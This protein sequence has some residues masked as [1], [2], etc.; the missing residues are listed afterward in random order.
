MSE[1]KTTGKQLA[2]EVEKLRREIRR[3][4][5][6]YYTD[7][8]PEISD[9]EFDQLM[10][11]LVELEREHPELQAIDSPSVRVGGAPVSGFETVIHDPPMLSIENAYSFDELREWDE[12]VRRS[13]GSGPV[14]YV[15]DLKIDGVS[16]DLLYRDG[17]MVRGATR[18]DGVRGDDVTSNVKT[19]RSLPLR[20]AGAPSVLEVRGE[21]YIDK[22]TFEQLNR[23]KEEEGAAPLANPRNS[24]AGSLRLLDP[25]QAAQRRL[26]AFV[27]NVVRA[28]RL[29]ATQSEVY[30]MLEGLGLP[31][32]PGRSIC[33]GLDQLLEFIEEW[34]EK[35]HSLPFDIDGIV[36]KVDRRDLQSELGVTSK[37]PR[38]A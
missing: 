28:D 7:A 4:E 8:A 36:I 14:D 37:A 29:P 34:R 1:R 26:R 20:L 21:V 17:V 5:Q 13:L 6:L 23:E 33:G 27:Y 35:R 19:I 11:R 38:W 16:I 15:A 12:R 30:Q 18:G 3:H 22:T 25:R 24:A 32:N 31:V 2:A 10:K 9:Y